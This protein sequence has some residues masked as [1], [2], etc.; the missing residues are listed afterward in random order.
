MKNKVIKTIISVGVLGS[1]LLSIK[2]MI[3]LFE[4]SLINENHFIDNTSFI[5]SN[6]TTMVI[7]VYVL[8]RIY[9]KENNMQNFLFSKLFSYSLLIY[10]TLILDVIIY[11]FFKFSLI[12]SSFVFENSISVVFSLFSILTT[13]YIVRNKD[14]KYS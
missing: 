8:R 14:L 4:Y 11:G 13:I 9:R 5:V 7:L 3:N 1:F 2:Y 12:E 10:T 6:T